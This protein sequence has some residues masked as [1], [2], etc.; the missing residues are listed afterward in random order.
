[1]LKDTE[2]R[3]FIKLIVK[4]KLYTL[5]ISPKTIHSLT[6]LLIVDKTVDNV[7]NLVNDERFANF[8]NISCA[9]S[10]QQITRV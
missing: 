3:Y 8:Y 1:M 6:F 9:H 2:I 10:Y 7:D 5:Y 4:N